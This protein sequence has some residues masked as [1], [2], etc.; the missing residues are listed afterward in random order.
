MTKQDLEKIS[1]F[2]YGIKN[3]IESKKTIAEKRNYCNSTLKMMWPSLDI[4]GPYDP[5]DIS[6]RQVISDFTDI[7]VNEPKVFEDDGFHPWLDDNR[8]NINFAFYGRYEKYLREV[9]HWSQKNL[10]DL[11]RCSDII[12]DHIG[13]PFSNDFFSKKGI[14]MGDIQ[15]GKT[16]NYTAVINKALDTGYKIIIVL[17]GIT[18]DLR[19]QTQ[20]RLDNEVTGYQKVANSFNSG[21]TASIGVGKITGGLIVDTLTYVDNKKEYGDIKKFFTIHPI[22][23]KSTPILAIVK[24]NTSILKNLLNCLMGSSD[25][26]YRIDEEGKKHLKFPVLIIDDEADQASVDTR[27]A[28]VESEASA[29][30]KRIRQIIDCCDRVSYVGYTA[31]PFANIFINPTNRSDLYPKDFILAIN[32]SIG[33]CGIKEYF[34]IDDNDDE[35]EDHSTDLFVNIDYDKSNWAGKRIDNVY[36]PVQTLPSSLKEAI[37]S[38]VLASCIKKSRGIVGFNSML[39]N[40]SNYKIKA[41]SLRPLVEDYIESLYEKIHFNYDFEINNYKT[42]YLDKF[43]EV[44]EERLGDKFNDNWDKIKEYIEQ[45]L[46]SITK[47]ILVL[48]GDSGDKLDYNSQKTGDFLIIGGNKLS[49]GLTLEGLTT[50]YY[51]RSARTY[52]AL[53]QMGRWFGYRSGW[54]DVCRVYTTKDYLNDFINVGKA[55][56]RFKKDLNVMYSQHL[57]PREVGQRILYSPN[58]IPTSRN[59]MYNAKLAKISLS[60]GV[61]Q[62]ISFDKNDIQSNLSLLKAFISELKNPEIRANGRIVFKDQ[63]VD[64]VINYLR[65][66]KE[67]S[68]SLDYGQ[69]SIKNWINYIEKVNRL[70]ELTNWTIVLSSSSKV[71]SSIIDIGGYKVRK[72]KRTLRVFDN[73]EN[74]NLYLLKASTNPGD[75]REFFNPN[76]PIYKTIKSY[77]PVEKYD[78]FDSKHGLLVLYVFDLYTLKKDHFDEQ[79]GKW[80]GKRGDLIVDA[81]NV[82]A[83]AIWFPKTNDLENSATDF[84]INPDYEASHKEDSIEDGE[85]DDL[86]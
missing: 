79:K 45:T 27:H 19:N 13:N 37:F 73:P 64:K 62:I 6:L 29:I 7:T 74:L 56:E 49:R 76:D 10:V 8:K 54:L 70:G 43:K 18:R 9:K 86:D 15:S 59:K 85:E 77:N 42:F 5:N 36:T 84:Y 71:D 23:K 68:N 31:T 82:S 60:N 11:N 46:N 78:G 63:S 25:E 20:T 65:K 38:F 47:H 48:N 52:D 4:S 28:Q 35:S 14:V 57:N 16:A 3:Q 40:V 30:N 53:L 81:Q 17:A 12:L 26:A 1:N 80:V 41:T 21:T 50:S 2:L 44:S 33:Y 75:F 67:C 55:I 69:I 61:Q 32:P 66:Y 34:G 83:P 39:I 51:F 22:T 72:P 58:L 24:K